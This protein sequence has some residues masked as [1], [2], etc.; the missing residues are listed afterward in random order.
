VAQARACRN[1]PRE[2]VAPETLEPVAFDAP[3]V[4]FVGERDP[5]TPPAYADRATLRMP[6]AKIVRIPAMAHMP[7]GTTHLECLGAMALAFLRDPTKPLDTTC[8]AGMKAP[9]FALR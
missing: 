9:A 5:V 7:D 2:P 4:V 3:V 1:W 6:R 8:V